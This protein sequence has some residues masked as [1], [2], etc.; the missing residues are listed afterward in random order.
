MNIVGKGA[1]RRLVT[2]LF[3]DLANFT[4]LCHGIDPEESVRIANIA[5]EHMSTIVT[6]NGGTIHKYEGDAVMCLFGFP[7]TYED[8]PERAVKTALQLVDNMAQINA[9]IFSQTG[10]RS[11]LGL[12]VGIHSGLTVVAEVGTGEKKEY[13]VMGDTV[14]LA[15]RLKGMAPAGQIYVSEQ[16]CKATEYLFDYQEAGAS[17]IKGIDAPV[18]LYR[19][20][21]VRKIPGTKRGIKGL[22]SP[23]VGRDAEFEIV[24]RKLRKLQDG[25]GG[26]L[27][28]TG[29]AGLGKSRLW[30]EAKNFVDDEELGIRI[31]EGQCLYHGEHLSYWPILQVMENIYSITDRDTGDVIREKLIKKTEEI[32]P[33]TWKDVVPYV[34]N[35]FSIQFAGELAQKVKYLDPREL[36]LKILGGVKTLLEGIASRTPLLIA[37]EDYHW[38]DSASLD[39][40]RFMFGKDEVSGV[41]LV[42]LSREGMAEEFV[43]VK[44]KLRDGAPDRFTDIVLKPLDKYASLELTYNLLEVPGFTKD[45]KDKVLAKA[46]G[47]PFF[48][49]EIINSLI[50]SGVLYFEAGMWKQGKKVEEIEIPDTI[51]LVIASRLDRLEENLKSV[52][53]MA[54]VI[55]R[56]FYQSILARIHEDKKRLME[57]LAAL[58]SYEFILKLL[59]TEDIEY[60]FKHP[61]IQQVTYSSLLKTK[62]RELHRMVAESMELVYKD[63]IDD[64]VSL[65]AQQ[66]AASDDCAKA[67]GWLLRAGKKAKAN[68]SNEDALECYRNVVS[69]IEENHMENIQALVAAHESTADIYMTIG[70]NAESIENYT[71]ILEITDDAL[72]QARIIR[73]IGDNYQ[74]QSRYPEALKYLNESKDKLD[75][76]REKLAGLEDPDKYYLGLH[77]TCHSIAWVYYLT[78]DFDRALAYCEKSLAEIAHIADN[79]ERNLASA[80]TLNVIAAIKGRT[81]KTEES[82][83]CY[84]EAERIYEEEDDL[85]GL[86][87]IYNNCVNY[88]SEKGDYISCIKYLEKSLEISVKTGNALGEAITSFNLSHEYLN[89]GKLDLAREYLERYQ[90]INKLINNRLGEGWANEGYSALYSEQGQTDKALERINAA[91]DIFKEVSSEIKEMSAKLSK[92]DLLIDLGEY[93]QARKLLGEIEAYAEKNSVTDFLISVY[94]SRGRILMKEDAGAALALFRKTETMVKELGWASALVDI[95]YYMGKALEGQGDAESAGFLDLARQKLKETAEKIKDENLRDSFLAKTFNKKVLSA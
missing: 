44:D 67:V 84:V 31:L 46:E 81:G 42:C 88:Y 52:L 21:R 34:G 94:V 89:L 11:E 82:Y 30:Q 32:L 92:T 53:Q 1:E 79:K 13:T 95:Y 17:T 64:F 43:K 93:A 51:Q 20:L 41:L 66:Y 48:L 28:I 65:I 73:K 76:L 75:E 8:A 37:V 60:M 61:L 59:S 69:I 2:V 5:F 45:F 19:P 36:Q 16:M 80:S 56:T 57:Y 14:N 70:K 91:I 71:R 35:L 12:H 18:R 6:G 29:N 85:A 9:S 15:S 27:F 7:L 72:T 58:E 62:R 39:F 83:E 55:G 10:I 3:A 90:R 23:L 26:I 47:N 25:Q 38:I 54:S 24:K 22:H 49:E 74:R 33:Q 77:S 50:D 78:G 68:F 4:A 86:G 87:T 40:I 63:R